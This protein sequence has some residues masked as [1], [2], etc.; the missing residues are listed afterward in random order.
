MN[1]TGLSI[2]ILVFQSLVPSVGNGVPVAE[3]GLIIFFPSDFSSCVG[4]L[5]SL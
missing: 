2:V 3:G 4:I 5:A 1:P